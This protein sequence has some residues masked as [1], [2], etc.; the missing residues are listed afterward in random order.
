MGAHILQIS[1]TF[2]KNIMRFNKI[3]NAFTR[4]KRDFDIIRHV[5]TKWGR[6]SEWLKDKYCC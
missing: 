4:K 1:K 5:I 3:I 2:I 6:S